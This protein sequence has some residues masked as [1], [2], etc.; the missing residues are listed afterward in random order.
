MQSGT[1][2]KTN[3][4]EGFPNLSSGGKPLDRTPNRLGHL[5]PSSRDEP[6]DVLKTRFREDGYLWLK[7]LLNPNAVKEFRAWVF[8]YLAPTGM[9]DPDFGYEDGISANGAYDKNASERVLMSLVRSARFEGFC[10]QLSLTEFIDTF[11]GTTS[12]LHK[13]KIMRFTCPNSGLVTP[14]HYDLVYLRGGTDRLVTAWIPIGDISVE[15]GG[16][17]YLEYSHRIGRALEADFAQKNASLPDAERISAFNVNMGEG[18]AISNDLSALAD[19]YD[20]RWL[21]ANYEAGDVVLHDPYM[22][23]ATTDNV[24][25]Q[26]RIR[27]STDIR[28]QSVE[29]EIDARWGDHWSLNDML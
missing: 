4:I 6:L 10:A 9:L 22:V 18:G 27:L 21:V 7:S 2:E 14:A 26:N 12:Y 19:Q 11:L 17:A 20:S 13:R 29:D 15:E 8:G 24:S 23:H 3:Q 28:F 16:L 5:K 1:T 25:R